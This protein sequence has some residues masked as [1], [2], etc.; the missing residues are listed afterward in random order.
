MG[1]LDDAIREHLQ[2]KLRHGTDP[3]EVARLEH[4]ALAPVPRDRKARAEATEELEAETAGADRGEPVSPATVEF[5]VA[6]AHAAEGDRLEP[7]RNGELAPETTEHDRLWFEQSPPN[8][9]DF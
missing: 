8:K 9:F 6:A 2:L 7:G 1:L 3:A 4:E 5:D